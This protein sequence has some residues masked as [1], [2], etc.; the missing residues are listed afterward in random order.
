MASK[1]RVQELAYYL[2]LNSD[3]SQPSSYYWLRAEHALT[4]WNVLYGDR[5]A[6][7][8]V[9]ALAGAATPVKARKAW[10]RPTLRVRLSYPIFSANIAHRPA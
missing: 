10:T 8:P 9:V 4:P 2:W 7:A 1:K 6:E 5:R 3:R